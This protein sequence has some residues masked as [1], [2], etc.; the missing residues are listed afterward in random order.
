MRMIKSR[1][2]RM[3]KKYNE[4]KHVEPSSII[5]QEDGLGTDF[6]TT[7][8]I[9]FKHMK[10]AYRHLH[11]VHFLRPTYNAVKTCEGDIKQVRNIRRDEFEDLLM[12]MIIR[13]TK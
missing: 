7:S 10:R 3:L 6:S 9:L 2:K 11:S 5:L 13:R 8:P 1:K 4:L 12:S